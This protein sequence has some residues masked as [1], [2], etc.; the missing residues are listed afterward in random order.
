[1]QKI[2]IIRKRG[3]EANGYRFAF[4]YENMTFRMNYVS[5]AY[6]IFQIDPDNFSATYS[7]TIQ[8]VTS[9]NGYSSVVGNYFRWVSETKINYGFSFSLPPSISLGISGTTQEYYEASDDIGSMFTYY[10]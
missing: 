8:K 3:G 10:E 2:L 9:S 1:M 4:D 5:N 6:G 7:V